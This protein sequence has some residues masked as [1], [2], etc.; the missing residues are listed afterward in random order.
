MKANTI[1]YDLPD[2]PGGWS[3]RN[4]SIGGR[5]LRLFVPA[6]PDASLDDPEL[7]EAW[8]NER[9]DPY[10]LYTWSAAEPMARIVSTEARRKQG[11][12]LELGCGTGLVGLAAAAAGRTVAFSDEQPDAVRTALVNARRNG[13]QNA[14]GLVLNWRQPPKRQWP[15]IVG[16]DLVY[17]SDLHRPLLQSINRLLPDDGEFWLGDPGRARLPEFLEMVSDEGLRYRLFDGEGRPIEKPG[18]MTFCRVVMAKREENKPRTNEQAAHE[19]SGSW[20]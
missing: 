15:W 13:L 9:S 6:N 1:G 14:E 12:V 17:F 3:E 8:E 5:E 16:S 7:A 19:V 2:V 20:G 10:W 11:D 4:W 18:T